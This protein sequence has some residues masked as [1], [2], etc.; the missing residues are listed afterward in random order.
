VPKFEREIDIDAPVEKVW[1]IMT[2]PTSWPHWFPGIDSVSKLATVNAGGTFEWVNE[3][4]VGHGSIVAL[5]PMKSLEVITQMDE[6][7]DLHK[8]KLRS[9]GGFLGLANDECKVE[10]VLDTL[11]GGGIL[12]N[13]VSGGNP[14][15]AIKVKKTMHNLRKYVES[16]T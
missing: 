1:Q 11:V 8:F 12:G 6:D 7:K 4:K 9:T 10:Y 3:G 15:D 5:D 14:K 13:F 2:D 16:Q